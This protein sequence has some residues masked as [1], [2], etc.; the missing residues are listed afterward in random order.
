MS[1]D[2]DMPKE[3]SENAENT[4]P[5]EEKSEL[6]L[7]MEENKKKYEFIEDLPGV[8]Q[9]QPLNYVNS[10]TTQLNH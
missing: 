10:A 1:E 5:V 4:E 7:R 6:V 2:T 9:Q 3:N 8:G